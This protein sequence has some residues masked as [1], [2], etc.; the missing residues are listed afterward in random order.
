MCPSFLSCEPQNLNTPYSTSISFLVEDFPRYFTLTGSTAH[1]FCLETVLNSIEYPGWSSCHKP[2]EATTWKE[3]ATTHRSHLKTTTNLQTVWPLPALCSILH[4]VPS[5]K[6]DN[7]HFQPSFKFFLDR[8]YFLST[9]LF[10]FPSMNF[11]LFNNLYLFLLVLFISLF[12]SPA[13]ISSCTLFTYTMLLDQNE[14]SSKWEHKALK[15][16]QQLIG[17]SHYFMAQHSHPIPSSLVILQDGY[18]LKSSFTQ[19]MCGYKGSAKETKGARKENYKINLCQLSNFLFM[20]S[21]LIYR[22]Q[23]YT[24][25]S[26]SNAS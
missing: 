14:K 16:F 5:L 17:T 12:H 10:I 21:F 11:I 22:I 18:V 2:Y 25:I 6:H 24:L 23:Q 3:T 4:C 13:P 15:Y 8:Q 19:G 20:A 1:K 26:S 9:F 7:F